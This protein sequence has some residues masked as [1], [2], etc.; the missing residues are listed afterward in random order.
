MYKVFIQIFLVMSIHKGCPHKVGEGGLEN[1]NATVSSS[2]QRPNYADI[3]IK[4][5]FHVKITL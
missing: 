5:H 1:V 2:L 3:I 4:K